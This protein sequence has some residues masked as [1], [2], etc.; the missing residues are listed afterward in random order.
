MKWRGPFGQG[1]ASGAL[2]ALVASH[3][4]GGQYLRARVTPVNSNTEQQQGV[5]NSLRTLVNLWNS[6]LTQEQRDAWDTYGTNVPVLDRL[7]DSRKLTGQNWFVAVNTVRM[8][9]GLAQALDAP[10]TFDTGDTGTATIEMGTDTIGTL[11]LDNVPTGWTDTTNQ[12]QLALYISRPFS[13]S[14][15]FFKG[16]FQYAGT[17][18]ASTS[19]FTFTSPFP[20][21]GVNNT[22]AFQYR[23]LRADGRMSGLFAGRTFPA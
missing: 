7:G 20:I 15:S 22:A 2:G 5:R 10:T 21:T 17:H 3:N 4:R 19:T 14:R 13:A 23:I 18:P 1:A 12:Q 11:T 8:Q 6:T 9:A 16:P